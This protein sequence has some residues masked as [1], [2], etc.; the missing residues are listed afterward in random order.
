MSGFSSGGWRKAAAGLAGLLVVIAILGVLLVV[1]LPYYTTYPGEYGSRL[2][3]A[4]LLF[5]VLLG[6]AIADL[7]LIKMRGK[8]GTPPMPR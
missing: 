2:F 4:V 6:L 3:L 1:V 8:R 5:S 7:S